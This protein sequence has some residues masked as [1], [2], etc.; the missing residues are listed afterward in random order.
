MPDCVFANV[1][2]WN[3]FLQSFD[4]RYRQVSLNK[5]QMQLA[6]NDEFTLVVAH[7]DPGTDNWL[8]T[9]GHES[10]II[11]WRFMLPNGELAPIDTEKVRLSEV[12]RLL[13]RA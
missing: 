7:S 4:Y 11:Y 5:R 9:E 1:L 12:K 13:G 3:R 6:D 8:D 2:L 10:G